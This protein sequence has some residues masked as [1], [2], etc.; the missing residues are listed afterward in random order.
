MS[1]ANTALETK[2]SQLQQVLAAAEI[3]SLVVRDVVSRPRSFDPASKNMDSHVS[4]MRAHPA[5]NA[6]EGGGRWAAHAGDARAMPHLEARAPGARVRAAP[7]GGPSRVSPASTHAS[8][9]SAFFVARALT[10]RPYLRIFCLEL[11]V[12]SAG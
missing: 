2:F 9:R 8:H 7:G 3:A 4:R 11:R 1:R 12:S 5:G 6:K 10:A